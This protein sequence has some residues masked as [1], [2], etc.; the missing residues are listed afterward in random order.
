M[1]PII[2]T[3]G[4]LAQLRYEPSHRAH[5]A[6]VY[7]VKAPNG[8]SIVLYAQ[9]TGVGIIWRGG[10]PL[11]ESP[12]A[13]PKQ[14]AK[15]PTK[16]NGTSND[17]IMII[18]SD[19]EATPSKPTPLPQADFEDEEEELDPDQ[20]YP[21]IVQHLHLVLNAEVCHIAIP[22]V[23]VVSAL[24]SPGTVPPIFNSK[25]V[26][27]VACADYSIRIVTLP[28]SPPPKVAKETSQY[29]EEVTRIPTHAAHQ[30]IP[31]G[32]TMTWTARGEPTFDEPSDNRM[33]ID[34]DETPRKPDVDSSKG[35][36]LL[37]ASH[38][39]E[40]GGLLKI[41]RFGLSETGVTAKAPISAYQTLHLR[42]PATRI[43]FNSALYPKVRHSQLLITDISGIV[44][45][46]DPFAPTSDSRRPSMDSQAG[47]YVALFRAPFAPLTNSNMPP[48]LAPRKRILDAAWTSDGNSIFALLADGEWG[49]WDVTRAGPSRPSDPSAF[50]IRGYIGTSEERASSS[51]PSTKARSGRG[52]LAPMTPNTRRIKE[53]KLFHGTPSGPSVPSR[54]AVCVASLPSA[55]GSAPEESVV[56]WYGS[57]VYRIPN[58]AQ[59][60]E[61]T[62]SANAG[63]SLGRPSPSQLQGP[64]LFG[65]AINSVAQFETTMRN[66]RMAI[67]RDILLSTADRL[68]VVTTA[69]EPLDR[70]LDAGLGKEGTEEEE[71]RRADRA[72]LARGELD[73]GGMDRLL[74]DMEGSGTG[75]QSLLAGNPRRVL[76][77]STS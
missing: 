66:S 5:D 56:I 9:E 16:V 63:N 45:I 53:E 52:S 39:T 42:S 57:D 36:D 19:D 33:E 68:I 8:S 20:P 47:A 67:P 40:L 18:D 51:G 74:E 26:F 3:Q 27:S 50:S 75:S 54:G 22:N 12:A 11:K 2:T 17:A 32:I 14:P 23:P 24:R 35:W 76:F 28:L 43:S 49:I 15:P 21:P 77:A 46:Y 1:K 34:D 64:N 61:R 10:R 25:I 69:A 30:S 13:P 31:R 65:E 29:G 55:D 6:H 70:N 38:S 37:I 48:I 7:P 4:K 62:A 72:L 73:L 44:R 71:T 58:L 59:F 41:F 60:W